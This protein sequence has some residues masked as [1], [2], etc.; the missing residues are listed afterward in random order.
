MRDRHTM[1]IEGMKGELN[2]TMGVVW[3][4]GYHFLQTVSQSI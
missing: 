1:D 2:I 4:E 3:V